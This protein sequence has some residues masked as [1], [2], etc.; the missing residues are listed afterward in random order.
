MATYLQGAVDYIPQIQPFAPN[1]NL[2]ANVLQTKQSKYD[3]N[4]K[5]LNN[6]YS[7]YF[8]ADLSH[9]D[10]QERRDELMTAIDFNLKK[11][12]G[13]DLSLEQ[14]VRQAKQL[15]TPFYE[16]KY[17]MRDMVYTKN[18]TQERNRGLSY[19]NAR[20]EK[21]KEN[22]WD[23]GI[24]YLDY[25]MQEFKDADL[26][27]TLNFGGLAYT[28]FV[29][30]Q[31]KAMDLAKQ[32]GNVE[33]TSFSPD[34][35]YMIVNR[36]GEQLREPLH[37][38]FEAT[39]GNDPAAQEMFQVMAYVNRKDY[40]QTNASLFGGDAKQ[41]EMKYLQDQFENFSKQQKLEFETQQ[42]NLKVINNFITDLQKQEEA[43]TITDAGRKALREYIYS[44]EIIETNLSRAEKLNEELN[45]DVGV[46]NTGKGFQNPYEDIETLRRKVDGAVANSLFSKQLQEAA[47]NYSIMN[48]KQT[49]TADPFA[50]IDYRH[51]KSIQLAN[52]KQALKNAEAK[53]EKD[54]ELNALGLAESFE[55]SA[56]GGSA[57]VTEPVSPLAAAKQNM[58]NLK[59][60][61]NQ[62]LGFLPPI[63]GHLLDTGKIS[64]ETFRKFTGYRT[65]DEFDR[66]VREGKVIDDYKRFDLRNNQG[67]ID[68]SLT[69][70]GRVV[71]QVTRAGGP[72]KNLK[73]VVVARNVVQTGRKLDKIMDDTFH[74]LH[75]HKEVPAINEMYRTFAG[76]ADSPYLSHKFYKDTK[77]EY[78]TWVEKN[79]K[80]L[81]KDLAQS[82]VNWEGTQV[83]FLYG[84]LSKEKTMEIFLNT[85]NEQSFLNDLKK[86]IKNRFNLNY[87]EFNEYP[88][89]S[90]FKNKNDKQNYLMALAQY[91]STEMIA[92]Y[93]SLY[94]KLQENLAEIMV[95]KNISL[96]PNIAAYSGQIDPTTGALGSFTPKAVA[97]NAY[98]KELRSPGTFNFIRALR[99]LDN[100]PKDV[101]FAFSGTIAG[102]EEID[103]N[104]KDKKNEIETLFK[105]ITKD[106]L[107]SKDRGGIVQMVFSP[108]AKGSVENHSLQFKFDENYLKTYKERA[109]AIGEDFYSQLVQNGSFTVVAPAGSFNQIP[110]AQGAQYTQFENMVMGKKDGVKY[111]TMDG[112]SVRYKYEGDGQFSQQ[113]FDA[114]GVVLDNIYGNIFTT[115]AGE[116]TT[117]FNFLLDREYIILE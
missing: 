84:S 42:D 68:Y 99:V 2:Y 25:K 66:A 23:A 47:Q 14:N 34:G 35:R 89:D 43:G 77:A 100:L 104:Y 83:D 75:D 3:S 16:D 91:T 112:G 111:R 65:A 19:K 109:T 4:W 70:I 56:E 102:I 79:V 62:K 53:A 33:S 81:A 97:I 41:A 50:V 73:P 7:Q 27:E 114:S 58:Q 105:A 38:L 85:N 103:N 54:F 9:K 69:N 92:P 110:F 21:D 6:V 32:F 72:G 28:P 113:I 82:K 107:T 39:F 57:S 101:N 8:Y 94:D 78:E 44:K 26:S 20:N 74:Y 76:Y 87:F 45:T 63:L 15:F 46:S 115:Q 67:E 22:Y 48:M 24:K 86:E 61:V 1:L 90:W 30:I 117:S 36:N 52:H 10:N 5:S 64:E 31:K 37:R 51:K 88:E 95:D 55:Y 116:I 98:N 40:A 17:L 11:V 71:S 18:Y 96:P 80:P 93:N 60:E 106:Y 59:N 29:N 49:V 108:I 12:S 13:L